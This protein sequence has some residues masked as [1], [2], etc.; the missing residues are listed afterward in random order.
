[1]GAYDYGQIVQLTNSEVRSVYTGLIAGE[2]FPVGTLGTT[3]DGRWF[4]F[5]RNGGSTLVP[6]NVVSGVAPVTNQVGNTATATA[7]GATSVTFTQGATAITQNQYKDGYLSISV[8]PG[9]GYIYPISD[10]PAVASATANTYRLNGDSVQVALTTT[11]RIDL[12]ANP[13]RGVIQAAATTLTSNSVGV[14]VS[15]PT[16]GQY[17][18]VQ[19]EGPANVLTAGTLIVG[20]RAVTPTGVA[21]AAGP[22]TATAAN[23]KTESTIGQVMRV[24]AD[25][26]WSTIDLHLLS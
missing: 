6:G 5:A 19:V 22:E 24:A 12:V 10:H 14:A 1:M 3:Q 9:A 20:Q 21:G 11:S 15:A 13:F 7:A 18:W 8:T 17:C 25:T 26:A 23:S 2:R 16:S 4:R